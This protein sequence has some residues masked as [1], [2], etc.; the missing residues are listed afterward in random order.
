MQSTL[1]GISRVIDAARSPLLSFRRS[2]NF[3]ASLVFN[4]TNLT[5]NTFMGAWGIKTFENDGALDWLG[6]FRDAP[7]EA[8]FRQTFAPQPPKGF[9]SKLFGGGS[10]ASPPELDGEDVLAAAE[11]L[12]TLRGHPAVDAMEDLADLPD[13]KV[14]DEIV[15]LAIQAI[16]SVMTSSDL[17]DCWEDTDD[18][19][20]WVETVKDIRARLSRA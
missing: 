17:K 5:E 19:E 4:K 1:N 16:D 10:S 8:K 9:L 15:A 13:I 20:S 3:D 2:A 11:I 14:T 7:S 12:A 6:D 18:F